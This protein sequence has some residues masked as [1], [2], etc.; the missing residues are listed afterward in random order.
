MPAINSTAISYAD[1][2]SILREMYITFTS[3]GTYTFFEV[4]E[5]VYEELLSAKSKGIYYNLY[6]RDRY[7]SS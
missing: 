6:I 1:Y 4:P 2:N 7:R 3:G 5:D